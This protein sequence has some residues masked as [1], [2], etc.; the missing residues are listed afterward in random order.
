MQITN[1]K[2]ANNKLAFGSNLSR[3]IRDVKKLETLEQNGAKI[4]QLQQVAERIN[5]RFAAIP[6]KTG[7]TALCKKYGKLQ[8]R[9]TQFYL[10][11]VR[12]RI[13]VMKSDKEINQN[14]FIKTFS[15]LLYNS[16]TLHNRVTKAKEPSVHKLVIGKKNYRFDNPK[17]LKRLG[18]LD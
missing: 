7:N 12:P 14:T 9:L 13:D 8:D 17:V 1:Q 11:K 16:Q 18:F 5:S 2:P 4:E 3:I 10:N 6:E 15:T